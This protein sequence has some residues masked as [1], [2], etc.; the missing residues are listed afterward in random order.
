MR[1]SLFLSRKKE[2][3][4]AFCATRAIA[5]HGTCSLKWV[6]RIEAASGR[7]SQASNKEVITC[8]PRIKP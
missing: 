4:P 3:S 2:N 6:S 1:A 7:E 5:W 8:E